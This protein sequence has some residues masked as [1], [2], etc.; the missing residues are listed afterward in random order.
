[1]DR[2]EIAVAVPLRGNE[3]LLRPRAEGGP[4][5]GAWEFPGGKIEPGEEPL[6]AAMREMAEETGLSGGRWELLL[7]HAHDYPDRRV[8]LHA[9]LVRDLEGAPWGGRWTWVA[10]T[11]LAALSLPA[12][13][14]PILEALAGRIPSPR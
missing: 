11:H 1:M 13:N 9:F 6:Q 12:A 14:G 4:L 5:A 3:V 7:V 2:L 10:W 8:R